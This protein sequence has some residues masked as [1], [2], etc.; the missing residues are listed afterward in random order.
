[1]A[2]TE[3]ELEKLIETPKVDIEKITNISSD[4]KTL[5]TRVP[6]NI[7]EDLGIEKG[8]KFRWLVDKN[9]IALDI[10]K[11]DGNNKKK[12]HA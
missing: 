2:I 12:K 4:G 8:D 9:K 1:M 11:E 3:D 7:E 6:K 10:I 5:L